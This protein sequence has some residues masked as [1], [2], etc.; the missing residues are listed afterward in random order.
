MEMFKT[1]LPLSSSFFT[2]RET[3]RWFYFSQKAR[4]PISLRPI[5][6]SA[7]LKMIYSV[8]SLSWNMQTAQ[9]IERISFPALLLCPLPIE[10]RGVGYFEEAI[11]SAHSAGASK[12]HVYATETGAGPAW[13]LMLT[14]G[15]QV[16]RCCTGRVQP[17]WGLWRVGGGQWEGGP[18]Q[19]QGGIRI[20]PLGCLLFAVPGHVALIWAAQTCTCYLAGAGLSSPI[21]LPGSYLTVSGQISAA[22]YPA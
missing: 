1:P 2:W 4:G 10:C 8:Q 11:Q 3:E 18:A 12:K 5:N 22:S 21:G 6:T 9:G 13:G 19:G 14:H 7:V 20:W 15:Q 16:S 17:E